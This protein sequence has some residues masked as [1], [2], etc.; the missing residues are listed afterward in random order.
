MKN[1]YYLTKPLICLFFT[2]FFSTVPCLSFASKTTEVEAEGFA[3]IDTL[4]KE[5]AREKALKEAFRRAVEQAVGVLVQSETLVQNAELINDKVYSKSQ[6]FIKTY[7]ILSENVT[8]DEY[9]L[10]IH[11]KVSTVKIQKELTTLGLLIEQMGKPRILTLI[12]EQT[13]TGETASSWWG[14]GNT[15]GVVENIIFEKFSSAGFDFVDKNALIA[16]AKEDLK[17]LNTGN[18]TNDIALKL[19]SLGEAEVVII[20]Q[21]I[22]KAGQGL[23]GTQIKSCQATINLRAINAD[24]AEILA[25]V[26]RSAV[27]AHVDPI[28]GGTRAL[29]KAGTQVAEQLMSQIINKWKKYASGFYKVSLTVNKITFEQIKPFVE[30]LKSE[31]D[32]IEEVTERG[33]RGDVAK[34][35][36]AAS[37]RA[38]NLAK[39][40]V[41]KQFNG[42]TLEVLSTTGNTI[43]LKLSHISKSQKQSPNKA[44]DTKGDKPK[45]K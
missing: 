11:A 10:K 40:L 33:F 28:T 9:R 45:K 5:T 21:A 44:S 16:N 23:M 1:L 39:N 19:A 24:N 15:P 3:V 43:E 2:V 4:G 8:A 25:T 22:A 6:G 32:D 7:K 41:G 26:T 17:V 13:A 20:G 37:E 14:G 29:T 31:I 18:I 12:T 38:K 36:L 27:D 34:F 42:L 35:E 30:F